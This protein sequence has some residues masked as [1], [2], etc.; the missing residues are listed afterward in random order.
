MILLYKYAPARVTRRGVPCLPKK[1]EESRIPMR[2][3]KSR[4]AG[5]P[6]LHIK[7]EN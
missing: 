1:I 3:R 2:Q 4:K 6:P 5:D 7:F